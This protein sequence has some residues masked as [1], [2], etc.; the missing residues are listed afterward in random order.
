MFKRIF[1]TAFGTFIG[2]PISVI[3]IIG[4]VYFP[5]TVIDKAYEISLFVPTKLGLVRPLT[6]EEILEIDGGQENVVNLPRRGRYRIYSKDPIALTTDVTLISEESSDIIEAVPLY[7]QFSDAR[8]DRSE[9]QYVF[10]INSA[11]VYTIIINTIEENEEFKSDTTITIIP[12]LGNVLATTAIISGTIQVAIIA[13]F[14]NLIYKQ[15]HKDRIKETIKLQGRKREQFE[16]F[17]D[18][19]MKNKS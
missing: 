11:G 12:Y 9:P 7:D 19:E 1:S 14:I 13:F 17:I 6:M 8:I 15:I 18:N 3:L 4:L 16:I 10:S 2:I 5:S